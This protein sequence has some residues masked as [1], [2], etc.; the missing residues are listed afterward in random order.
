[1]GISGPENSSFFAAEKEVWEEER[2]RIEGRSGKE[3][4]GG[5]ELKMYGNAL[6][7]FETCRIAYE[8][9]YEF[10]FHGTVC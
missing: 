7:Q 8:S 2:I 10:Q 9:L 1:M 5:R 6:L 3:S 4:I